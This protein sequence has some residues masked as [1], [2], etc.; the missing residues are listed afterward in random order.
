M[1]VGGETRGTTVHI[2]A[3]HGREE[4]FVDALS[5]VEHVIGVPL[6]ARDRI[7]STDDGSPIEAVRSIYNGVQFEF[8][9]NLVREAM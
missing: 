1:R 8:R 7:G 3:N 6:I 4:I 9:M 2:N 5:I